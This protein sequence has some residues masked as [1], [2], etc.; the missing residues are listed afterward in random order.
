MSPARAALFACATLSLAACG[1]K[2]E[3]AATGGDAAAPA[4]AVA[5][6]GPVTP[7]SRKP[8]LWTQ[9]I[10]MGDFSQ[11][12][13]ICL[14]E[15]VEKQVSLWGAQAGEEM[16]QK[17]EVTRGPGGGYSFTSSCDMGT[18]GRTTTTGTA[19]GDF[20]SKYRVE[21]QTTTEG[22]S[23]PQMNGTRAMVV[24]AAWQGPCPADFKPGDMELPGGMKM[25]LA[26]M[27]GAAAGAQ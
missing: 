25:N 5:Q 26:A 21:A 24:E 13:R 20:S 27:A 16:C 12:T 14:D 1:Q 6:A 23:A 9:T 3:A 17:N 10:S 2:E 18:G 19:T 15:A 4:A 11:T 8:G 7:P 22:A